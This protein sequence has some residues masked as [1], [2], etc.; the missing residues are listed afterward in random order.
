MAGGDGTHD[1][2]SLFLAMSERKLRWHRRTAM[3]ALFDV[4]SA[5]RV[6]RSAKSFSRASE[7]RSLT[8]ED[9]TKNRACSYWIGIISV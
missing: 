6:G 2:N 7:G 5:D 3:A 8:G 4:R 1:C 9:P